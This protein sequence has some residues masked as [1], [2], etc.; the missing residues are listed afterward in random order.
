MGRSCY[1]R[2]CGAAGGD[3]LVCVADQLPAQPGCVLTDVTAALGF[4]GP[5]A[6]ADRVDLFPQCRIDRD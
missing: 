5:S 2:A 6:T 3:W 1:H 4:P